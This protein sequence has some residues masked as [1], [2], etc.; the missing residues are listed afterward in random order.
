[1]EQSYQVLKAIERHTKRIAQ[2][3]ARGHR[4]RV[5]HDGFGRPEAKDLAAAQMM[6][7]TPQKT[8]GD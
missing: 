6:A 3:Q 7:A 2:Q 1:M 8:S 4:P 5:P